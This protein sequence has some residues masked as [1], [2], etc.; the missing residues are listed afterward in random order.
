MLEEHYT[1]IAKLDMAN[2]IHT[3]K[4]NEQQIYVHL[5]YSFSLLGQTSAEFTSQSDAKSYQHEY[6]R[7]QSAG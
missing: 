5:H 4:I 1:K 2:I 6:G 3:Y 7:V